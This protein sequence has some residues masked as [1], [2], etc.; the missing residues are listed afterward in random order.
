MSNK[1]KVQQF[2]TSD[3]FFVNNPMVFEKVYN[4]ITV[5][6]EIVRITML[7]GQIYF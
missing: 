2:N 6:R 7:I 4:Y 5:F 1:D 3:I